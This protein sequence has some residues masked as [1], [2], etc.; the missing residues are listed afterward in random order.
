M[1]LI[2]N[3]QYWEYEFDL[4]NQSKICALV[5]IKIVIYHAQMFKNMKLQDDPIIF[6]RYDL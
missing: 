3:H 6:C 4:K 1:F 2:L 5:A